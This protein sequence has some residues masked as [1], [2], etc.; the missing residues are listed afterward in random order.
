METEQK[1]NK[2]RTVTA[3]VSSSVKYKALKTSLS[4]NISDVFRW[5]LFLYTVRD[6]LSKCLIANEKKFI[7]FI[8]DVAREI[9]NVSL[10]NSFTTKKEARVKA[11]V[12]EDMNRYFNKLPR[13]E[14]ERREV[15][16]N[17]ISRF[18]NFIGDLDEFLDF[19]PQ[20]K[21]YKEIV[22]IFAEAIKQLFEV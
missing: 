4:S 17:S 9:T 1:P 18:I 11:R 14:F 16:S 7:W 10:I 6:H 8:I 2:L 15:L 20:E 12:S 3:Q 19:T 21:S 5:S 22:E 13:D